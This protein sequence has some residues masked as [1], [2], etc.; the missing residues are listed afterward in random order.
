MPLRIWNV[1]TGALIGKPVIGDYGIVR[2]L[3]FT[4]DGRRVVTGSD[5]KTVQLWDASTS[6]P[7]SGPLAFQSAVW[8]VAFTRDGDSIVAVSGDAVQMLNADPDAHLPVET[9]GSKVAAL[10]PYDRFGLETSAD[11][12][13]IVVVRDNAFHR[14]NADTGAQTGVVVSD[15]L[16]S[17]DNAESSRDNRWLAIVGNDNVIRVVDASNGQFVGKPLTGHTDRI[18]DLEFSPDGKTLATASDDN[19]VRM[20]DWRKGEQ[21]GKSL[22][23]HEY[24]VETVTFSDD[25]THLFSRGFDSVW[26][27]DMTKQPPT[28]KQVGGPNNPVTFTAM[29]VSRNGRYVATGSDRG[30][31][32]QWDVDSGDKH[33]R[34]MQGHADEINDLGYSPDGRY[35]VS[36]GAK[37]TDDTLR[38]WDAASGRQIGEPV[39]TEHM[40]QATYVSFSKDGHSVYVVAQAVTLQG[41]GPTAGHSA[42]WRLPAPVEWEHTLCEKLEENPSDAQ[43]KDWV[44]SEIPYSELC[45]GKPRAS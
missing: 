10:G 36:A 45:P 7:I 29:T 15:A 38:F 22:T 11:T 24:G 32:Q 17:M 27:W 12:P 8:Q 31:I 13:Q 23:G 21:I 6:Q 41:S 14:L 19:T 33:G 1:E 44:S 2:S 40:G 18:N 5:D 20:W 16:R 34:E 43:W 25:G 4:P 35:L 30:G 3:A 37:G 26:I 28:G 9:G 39:G 42:I